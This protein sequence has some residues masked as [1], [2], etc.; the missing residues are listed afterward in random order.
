MSTKA[1]R[2]LSVND[3]RDQAELLDIIFYEVSGRRTDGFKP[4]S[5]DAG[6][7]GDA[8]DDPLADDTADIRLMQRL[9][10]GTLAIRMRASVTTSQGRLVADVAAIFRAPEGASVSSH[11]VTQFAD[12]VATPVIRPYLREAIHQTAIRLGIAAPL[13]SVLD[14]REETFWHVEHAGS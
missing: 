1:I 11:V 6:G 9:E 10:G 12:V 13:L 5:A 2:V 8:G 7:T 3:L 4:S 14:T